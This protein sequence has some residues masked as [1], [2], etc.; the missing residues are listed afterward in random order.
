MTDR[1][2]NGTAFQDRGGDA[3]A[4]VLVHG[5]GLN[6]GMWCWQEAALSARYRL[7]TYDLYGHG[8][9]APP[10]AVPDLTLFSEQLRGLLDRLALT[11]VAVVGF[12]L[13]GMIA[14]RFAMDHGERLWA[15]AVLNSAHARDAAA[16][17]AIRD[18]VALA[19]EKGPAATVEAAL[20][21]WFGDS[22]RARNAETMDLVRGWLLANDPAV[23]AEIYAVLAEGVAELVAPESAID[24]PTLVMT[25]E[26]DYG[27]SPA[28]T[29]AIAAEISKAVSI[30]LPGL[31][32][33][34]MV[35]APDAYNRALLSFLGG[36][37]PGGSRG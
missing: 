28:M 5:F 26:E 3:P 15:L 34:A 30:V 36:H 13:G 33:M 22:F 9:S 11:E 32:H 29:Q 17:Q 25:G 4:V 37:A 7:V 20:K 24:C 8:E 10:P 2:P 12:S 6:R 31:R 27:N 18:R 21:R 19:R 1:H 35:E 23:Y 14:R 16:Q